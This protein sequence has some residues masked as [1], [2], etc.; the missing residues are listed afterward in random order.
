MIRRNRMRFAALAAALGLL[1]GCGGGSNSPGS[2]ALPVQAGQN[3]NAS[4]TFVV[5]IP[6][7]AAS[8][9]NSKRP[10]YITANVKAIDFTVTQTANPAYSAYVFYALTP[11]ST[12]CTSGS[13]GL[14][15]TL[16]V[17]AAPGSDTFVV[18]LYD[19]TEPGF[20]YIISTGYV[21]ATIAA[22][23]SNNISI[24]TD[25]VPTF[26]IAGLGNPFPPTGTAAPIPL[27]VFLTDGD[28][29]LIVGS[30]DS[31]VQLS[32][33]DMSGAT[34]LSKTALNQA[35]DTAGLT[36]AYTGAVLSSGATITVTSSNPLLTCCYEYVN[37]TLATV[38]LSPGGRGAQ[39]S[40][41]TFYFANT[42]AAAQTFMV[43]GANGGSGPFTVTTSGPGGNSCSGIV[44]VTGTSP[45]FTVTPVASTTSTS[46]PQLSPG[47]CYIG[48]SDSQGDMT[49]M[50]V[51]VGN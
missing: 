31:S 16:Q 2:S 41:Q 1:A 46:V 27:M 25:G 24:V 5:K 17:Q 32:D 10:H 45:N 33:S 26:A 50:G 43:T 13:S 29:D 11:Q 8:G 51:I 15:C 48:V 7:K 4:A 34:T 3:T 42:S 9:T 47:S 39:P 30:Y 28:G 49:A 20:S 36:L 12:Y 35:S 21:I 37:P 6:A 18:N 40:Q 22:Q 44:N 23:Q 14:T 38:A 19:G